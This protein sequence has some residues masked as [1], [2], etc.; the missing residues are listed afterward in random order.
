V[1]DH[2]DP[3]K[4]SLN[5][6]AIHSKGTRPEM[7]VQ[8]IIRSLG[9]RFGTN[10]VKLPGKPDLVFRSRRKVIF[11]H[12][13]FWHRHKGCGRSSTPATRSEFWQSKFSSNVTR[14]RRVGRE[15]KKLGWAVLVVWQC[16]L[17]NP[18]KLMERLDDYLKA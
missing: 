12:G 8:K 15:L 10:N 9:Y 11:V 3:S 4:R 1:T 2:V 6:A 17:R 16:E 13:C 14:D 7:A 18:G 5:M